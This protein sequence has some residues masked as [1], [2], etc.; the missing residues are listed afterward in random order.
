MEIGKSLRGLG[1]ERRE[2]ELLADPARMELLNVAALKSQAAAAGLAV[3]QAPRGEKSAKAVAQSIVLREL[4][5]RTGE[6]EVLAKAASAAARAAREAQGEPRRFAAARMQQ[7]LCA[8][9]AAEL[10][11][12]DAAVG[13]ASAWLLEAEQALGCQPGRLNGPGLIRARIEA[14]RAL[15]AGDRE[16]AMDTAAKFD[17][18]LVSFDARVRATGNGRMEAAA[19]RCE[20]AE[21]LI[22]LG[23]RSR[24]PGLLDRAADDL[25]QVTA[26]LDPGYLPLSWMRAETLRGQALYALGTLTGEPRVLAE[27]AAAHGGAVDQA[28]AGHSPIDRA[29]AG[30]GL[31]LAMQACAETTGQAK[32]FA[33][34]LSAFDAALGELGRDVQALPLRAQLLHDRAACLVRAA[35]RRN[36][37][38]S[39]LKVE[40]GFR[41][42]LASRNARADPIAW[43]VAQV[44][45]ARIYELRAER[46]GDCGERADA[47]VALSGAMEVF[48]EHR[49]PAL[50]EAASEALGRLKA[51]A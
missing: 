25:Q 3:H 27:A 42:Q 24:Q 8:L 6:P 14:R 7:A 21:L 43:A 51:R 49:L 45:L 23:V 5:R 41:E 44:A 13:S 20:R 30:R 1:R 2:G 37:P 33:S 17:Q 31:G 32:L 16:L 36:D 29:R 38:A 39:F 35:E 9:T 22:G 46:Q 48:A 50:I 28:P 11:C 15:V 10:F 4:A 18:A 47:A 26:E 40:S 34:A 12:D 19:A